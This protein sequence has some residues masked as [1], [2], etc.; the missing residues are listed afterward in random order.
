MRATG[1][2]SRRAFENS[3]GG[4][5]EGGD[6]VGAVCSDRGSPPKRASLPVGESQS[7]ASASG[8]SAGASVVVAASVDVAA[9]RALR[10]GGALSWSR[11]R[12]TRRRLAEDDAPVPAV[13]PSAVQL[14]LAQC[15]SPLDERRQCGQH[16]A[17]EGSAL[18][19]FGERDSDGLLFCE[20]GPK[21]AVVM[22]TLGGGPR[23]VVGAAVQ[24][25]QGGPRG[26]VDRVIAIEPAERAAQRAVRE[27][28]SAR[29]SVSASLRASKVSSGG[30]VSGP[31]AAMSAAGREDARSPDRSTP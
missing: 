1:R 20:R 3:L 4:L 22:G 29:A 31:V 16:H 6:A 27:R 14:L 8:T 18:L 26:G 24:D 13:V 30:N 17:G 11:G 15:A 10:V 19:G 23:L 21:G 28:G 5:G 25:P 12:R 7:R 9:G 2:A